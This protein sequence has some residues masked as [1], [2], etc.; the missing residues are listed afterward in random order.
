MIIILL[1]DG[2]EELEALT[3]VDVLR[4]ELPDKK[5]VTVGVTGRTVTGTHGIKVEADITAEELDLSAVEAAIFPGGMPGACNLDASPVTDKIIKRVNENG[6]ILGAIC[7]APLVLGRRGLLAGKEATCFP[8]FEG[9]L[10]GATVLDRDVVRS[11][12]IITAR[13]FRTSFE[14]ADTLVKAIKT[15]AA[16]E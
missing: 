4:R 10:F 12:N 8:G 6:G 14:F 7:A 3:P 16:V 1:A 11:A 9:E 2:F 15:P 13:N 5:T